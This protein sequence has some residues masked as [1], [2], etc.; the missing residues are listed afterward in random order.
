MTPVI[1][2]R[3]GS[4]YA[5]RR[6]HLHGQ[7]RAALRGRGRG[8]R[9][10]PGPGS[11]RH[12]PALRRDPGRDMRRR[13]G[14]S[15]TRSTSATGRCCSGARSQEHERHVRRR[16]NRSARRRVPVR[17][18]SASRP[19]TGSSWNRT[20]PGG[21]VPRHEDD[22]AR[23]RHLRARHRAH[24]GP[25]RPR[26]HR[27]RARRRP[28]PGRAG[29]GLGGVAAHTASSSSARPTSCSRAAARCSTRSFPTSPARSR[30]R[31]RCGSI[32]SPACRPAITDR[33]RGPAT[34]GS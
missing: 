28:G 3:S 18:R 10:E 5:V 17:A 4:K 20:A 1:T 22:R 29:G 30:P 23:R 21:V 33:A 19:T 7:E 26:R 12:V 8:P 2:A 27:P 25:R 31:A 32:R 16:T 34:S 14:C 11:R 15:T 24:A 13:R 6:R 9:L